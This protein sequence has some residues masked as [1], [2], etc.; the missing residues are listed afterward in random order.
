MRWHWDEGGVPRVRISPPVRIGGGTGRFATARVDAHTTGDRGRPRPGNS[1][2]GR[3]APRS[4]PTPVPPR[5]RQAAVDACAGL[6]AGFA[7]GSCYTQISPQQGPFQPIL[8]DRDLSPHSHVMR[9]WRG[10]VSGPDHRGR[11][12][13]CRNNCPSGQR[14]GSNSVSANSCEPDLNRLDSRTPTPGVMPE[15]AIGRVTG[16]P[17]HRSAVHR[18]REEPARP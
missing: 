8:R 11:H 12:R 17:V 1:T 2:R 3:P 16:A 4:T 10:L 14:S 15:R 13:A 6:P 18:A 5:K 7:H 9:E